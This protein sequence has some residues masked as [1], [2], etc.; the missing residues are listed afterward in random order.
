MRWS[1]CSWDRA[2]PAGLWQLHQV[3]ALVAA[4]YRVATVDNRSIPPSDECT[5][6][7]TIEDLVGD[8]AA[9]IEHLGGRPARV[10]GTSL[11][12]RIPQELAR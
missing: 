11:G 3:P 1:C 2:V 5:G 9:L 8:A 6:G 12:S 4:R 10:V 7:M